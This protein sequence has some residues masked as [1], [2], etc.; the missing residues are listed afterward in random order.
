VTGEGCSDPPCAAALMTALSPMHPLTYLD[1]ACDAHRR[2]FI[3]AATNEYARNVYES[4]VPD[5]RMREA[6]AR[7][8]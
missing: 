8:S 5:D 6:E 1:L 4:H 7:R 2:R 3:E